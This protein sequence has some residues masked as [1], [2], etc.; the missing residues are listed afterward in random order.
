MSTIGGTDDNIPAQIG[1]KQQLLGAQGPFYHGFA[2]FLQNF[3]RILYF[4][5]FSWFSWFSW[6]FMVFH[7][8]H[9]FSGFPSVTQGTIN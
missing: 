9:G 7:G 6:F 5:G 3:P 1:S 2:W 4:H 8:F